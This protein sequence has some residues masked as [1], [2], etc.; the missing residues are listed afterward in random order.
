VRRILP[1]DPADLA[2]PPELSFT[3]CPNVHDIAVVKDMRTRSRKSNSFTKICEPSR[4]DMSFTILC[5]RS[6]KA[7]PSRAV[8]TFTI[9]QHRERY[10]CRE[11]WKNSFTKIYNPSRNVRSFTVF[12]SLQ[13]TDHRERDAN[14]FTRRCLLHE[15]F[16]RSGYGA[17]LHGK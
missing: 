9:W 14:S 15:I 2:D 13:G 1:P 11:G 5:I 6:R 8:N 7:T 3:I 17:P 10:N 4:S 16:D 12:R